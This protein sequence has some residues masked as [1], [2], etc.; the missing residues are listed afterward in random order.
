MFF[1]VGDI[2]YVCQGGQSFDGAIDQLGELTASESFP[3]WA[4]IFI[5]YYSLRKPENIARL[6][7]LKQR[8]Q[9]ASILCLARSS[10]A[11]TH[12]QKERLGLIW[13]CNEGNMLRRHT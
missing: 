9:E 12:G 8:C 10:R 6:E 11:F 5:E 2:M 1:L 7:W 13:P 4:T 3:K